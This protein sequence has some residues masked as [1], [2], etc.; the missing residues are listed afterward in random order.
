MIRTSIS[1]AVFAAAAFA[2]AA[3][4]HADITLLTQGFNSGATVPGWIKTNAT[5]P[6][7]QG[8][9]NGYA[10]AFAAQAGVADSYIA[11]NFNTGANANGDFDLW[12]ITPEVTMNAQSV[13]SFYTRTAG[14]DWLDQLEVRY[15]AGSG[16]DLSGFTTVL[17]NIGAGGTYPTDWA[18]ITATLGDSFAGNG[19][20]AFRYT[21]NSAS[22]DFIGIDSVN[23]S[24][25]PE[26]GSIAL[27]GLGL[28]GFAVARRKQA[29]A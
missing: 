2:L 15:S 10:D 16:T 17:G 13:L 24:T 22:A 20:F 12:L 29:R 18:Q 25:V 4:A 3:S 8:W 14:A 9:F 1:K 21:G 19:R 5:A 23:L 11:A 7:G 27:L 6:A 28:V 26:P